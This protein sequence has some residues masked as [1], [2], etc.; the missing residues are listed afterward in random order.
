MISATVMASTASIHGRSIPRERERRD[1][2]QRDQDVAA[3]VG[4]VGEQKRASELAAAP[5]L[6]PDHERV[7][8]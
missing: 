6:V 5:P 1:R 2:E 3:R 8:R 4:R 7:H